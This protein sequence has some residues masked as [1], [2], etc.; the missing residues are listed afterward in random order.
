MIATNFSIGETESEI[1]LSA[2]C[3]VSKCLKMNSPGVFLR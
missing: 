2:F 3:G 1:R